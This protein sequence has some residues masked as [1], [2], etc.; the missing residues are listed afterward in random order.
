MIRFLKN[1]LFLLLFLLSKNTG[2]MGVDSLIYKLDENDISTARLEIEQSEQRNKI[3]R[4]SL[5]ATGASLTGLLLFKTWKNW[6][7]PQVNVEPVVKFESLSLSEQVGG[8]QQRVLKLE[9]VDTSDQPM[10]QKMAQT[11]KNLVLMN[12]PI[13][14]LQQAL[15]RTGTIFGGLDLKKMIM[16][17]QIDLSKHF[18]RL[19]IA[20]IQYDPKTFAA[21]LNH[22]NDLKLCLYAQQV[23][24]NFSKMPVEKIVE[25]KTEAQ[26][27]LQEE[28]NYVIKQMAYVIAYIRY[29][30]KNNVMQPVLDNCANQLYLISYDAACK[31]ETALA[32][33]DTRELFDAITLL[34]STFNITVNNVL[35]F[36]R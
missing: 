17:I 13:L 21:N 26:E 23:A 22:Q 9:K 6:N 2:L 4:Y 20:Q 8:L 27:V 34:Q 30:V 5:L 28:F 19:K 10:V 33:N 25:L 18:E 14:L 7:T 3:L 24:N 15:I 11:V 35:A 32:N 36:G 16:R 29:G 12:A 1:S 31:T